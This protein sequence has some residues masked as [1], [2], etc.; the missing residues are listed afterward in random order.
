MKTVRTVLFWCH[1][2]AGLV[3]GLIVLIMSVTGVL[4]TYEKQIMLW[5]DTRAT[6]YRPVDASAPAR[7]PERLLASAVAAGLSPTS[8]TLRADTSVPAS[9]S[10]PNHGGRGE[11]STYIDP[12]TGALLAEGS[13]G[14]RQFF[15]SM[16]LWH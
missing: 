10:S 6:G 5:A 13:P 11:R 1:L 12:Y 9:V 7:S 8:L 4:L 2:V 3:A 14:T 15:R 16:T